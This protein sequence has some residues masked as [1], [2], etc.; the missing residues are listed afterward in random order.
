MPPHMGDLR[1]LGS[2]V[3]GSGAAPPAAAGQDAGAGQ[4]PGGRSA[5]SGPPGRSA[6]GE[7]AALTLARAARLARRRAAAS[8]RPGRARAAAGSCPRGLPPAAGQPPGHRGSMA[9]AG[10]RRAVWY[11]S[12]QAAT[13]APGLRPG[14][15]GPDSPQLRIP[16]VERH[17][18]M[19]ALSRRRRPVR[20]GRVTSTVTVP[21]SQPGLPAMPGDTDPGKSVPPSRDEITIHRQPIASRIVFATCCQTGSRLVGS[22]V[23]SGTFRCSMNCLPVHPG[24]LQRRSCA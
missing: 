4:P 12:T 7:Q 19:T 24:S 2:Q 10:C 16:G 21:R 18:S 8:R 1:S 3:A 17:D 22:T 11:P 20:C 15:A 23:K 13:P 14:R 6:A 9:Q 5:R